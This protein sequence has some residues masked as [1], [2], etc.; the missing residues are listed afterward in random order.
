MEF[1]LVKEKHVA[2]KDPPIRAEIFFA[3]RKTSLEACLQLTE[4][5][6]DEQNER[7]FELLKKLFEKNVFGESNSTDGVNFQGKN[8]FHRKFKRF[9]QLPKHFK[10]ISKA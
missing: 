1:Y 2:F 4:A 6:Q 7:D 8:A 3:E 5:H 9:P 10:L